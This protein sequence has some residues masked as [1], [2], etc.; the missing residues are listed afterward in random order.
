M[1]RW[2]LIGVLSLA[3]IG[4]GFWGYR[5]HQEKNAILTQAENTYQRSFHELT[6]HMDLLHDQIGTALAMNS[7]ERLSPQFVEIWRLTSEALSNVGQLPLGL[8]PFNKTEEFLSNIGDFTYKTAVR[9]LENSPLTDEESE[10]LKQ[11]YSQSGDIKDELRQVQHI[12]LENNLRW[13]DVQLALAN[14][15][16]QVDNTI[17]D[18][19]KTV[20]KSVE[21][22][23]EGNSQSSVIG[24]SS[25]D[26]KYKYLNGDKISEQD[27]LEKS[28]EIFNVENEENLTIAESGEGSDVPMYSVSYHNDEKRAYMDISQQGGHPLNILVSRD[29]ANN[30]ISLNEGAEKAQ[31]YLESF[32]LDSMS[33][34]QSSEY[35][36]VGVYSFLYNENDV[37]VYSDAVEVK[38]ALDNGDVLG[39][40]TNNYY[41][42]HSDRDI[43]EPD[44][45]EEEAKEMV[46]P[47][48]DIQEEFLAVIDNDLGEEVLVYE[49]LGVL[50]NDTFRIFINAMN[51]QEEKV[52]K[53]DGTEINFASNF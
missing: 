36:N 48:V 38:V 11:L 52:E 19:F 16:E 44:I 6:Y 13:M 10:T 30:Q 12:A 45:S 43:P 46:N 33:L 18:G 35:N 7:T 50:D 42:N 26:H 27:A 37:R 34:F 32:D 9:N 20:E 25:N 47:N 15:D 8:L 17:I 21:G 14:P 24:T 1:V 4:T 29:I 3:L 40:S 31:D 49:F 41:M 53:L 5:E 51:G 28:K 39:L 22:F 23:N 2:I